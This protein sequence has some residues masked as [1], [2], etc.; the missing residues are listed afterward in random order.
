M[1]FG[2]VGDIALGDHPKTVGFGFRSMYPAGIPAALAKRVRPPGFE[3][4]LVFGNLEFVL[5][6][7]ADDT[8]TA[9]RQCMGGREYARFLA[10]AG[11]T[12]L[13]VANN[14]SFQHGT[15]AFDTTV[16]ILRASGIHVVG[17]PADFSDASV[18]HVGGRRVAILGWSDRP[19]QYAQEVPPYN[20]FGDDAY[21]RIAEAKRRADVV[22]ASI[23]W[24]DEFILVP[25]DRE[26]TIARALIDAGATF[27]IGHHPHVVRETEQYGGGVI[28]YS[29]GN[30]IGDMLWDFR[31]RFTGWLTATVG[32][33][34]VAAA[35]FRAGVIDD[36][37][38]PRPLPVAA[39]QDLLDEVGR[40]SSDDA[41]RVA[42]D[43]YDLVARGQLRRHA[44]RTGL[45]MLRNLHRYPNGMAI[46]MFRNAV[47]HRLR[48]LAGR[49]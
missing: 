38:F 14:H 11:I 47:G 44:R 20:E 6:D 13:N 43:G 36:D 33:D 26:R 2:F 10:D 37:Y 40:A 1:R 34:G 22:I 39:W 25:S 32:D 7:G 9:R 16:A 12:A 24:G 5:G 48:A 28:A 23:H 41:A 29:L 15:S 21:A 30:F 4:D 18:L 31:T 8:D 46:G 49:S 19:R 45:M 3:P 17:T 42:R 35:D 27:V